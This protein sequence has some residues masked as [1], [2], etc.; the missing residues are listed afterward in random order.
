M[1]TDQDKY[2]LIRLCQKQQLIEKERVAYAS[3]MPESFQS[4]INVANDEIAFIG[5]LVKKLEE[6]DNG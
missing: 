3:R 2:W 4:V 5:R 1:L 6:K